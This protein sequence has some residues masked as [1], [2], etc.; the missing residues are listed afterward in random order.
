MPISRLTKPIP[1]TAASRAAHAVRPHLPTPHRLYHAGPSARAPAC[2]QGRV[3]DRARPPHDATAHQRF[4]EP[5]PLPDHTAEGQRRNTQRCGAGLP[6]HLPRPRQGLH[7]ARC[8]ILGLSRQPPPGPRP[9]SHST[10][11]GT[12]PLPWAARLMQAT[13]RGFA[14]VTIWCLNPSKRWRERA[15][16]SATVITKHAPSLARSGP[17]RAGRIPWWFALV[18]YLRLTS[19]A[20]QATGLG[21]IL[22]KIG[23]CCH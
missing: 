8:G 10:P 23:K 4:R 13:A 22:E 5:H 21:K 9:G 11:A 19:V 17:D 15:Y 2:Q 12:R 18:A 20:R 14:P 16:L 7:K 6:R 1:A 3:A